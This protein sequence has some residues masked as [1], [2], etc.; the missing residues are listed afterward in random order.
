L[1]MVGLLRMPKVRTLVVALRNLGLR[2][3]VVLRSGE[4]HGS[5]PIW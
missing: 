2:W 4:G 1:C 3:H 5:G